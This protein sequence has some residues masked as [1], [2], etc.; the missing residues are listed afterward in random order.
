ARARV[1]GAAA[2]AVKPCSPA[3]AAE[4][5]VERRVR[6]IQNAGRRLVP[7]N[8]L[9]SLA[10]E[11]LGIVKAPPESLRVTA[12]HDTPF[13]PARF[14]PRAPP[15]P[16]GFPLG[17]RKCAECGRLGADVRIVPRG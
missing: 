6:G 7:V 10:P 11:A 17:G 2:Q 9:R 8:L 13:G 1:G 4:P 3:P 15:M 16:Y 12:H 5:S 14:S